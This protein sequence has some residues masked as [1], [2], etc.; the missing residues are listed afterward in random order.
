[1]GVAQDWRNGGAPAVEQG[2]PC[3]E[4][5]TT[6]REL[7]VS[8]DEQ[9]TAPVARYRGRRL[10][11]WWGLLRGGGVGSVLLGG[12]CKTSRYLRQAPV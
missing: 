3:V 6:A 11:V 2:A 9:A 4:S 5:Y 8:R 10:L 7:P 12:L 1:M